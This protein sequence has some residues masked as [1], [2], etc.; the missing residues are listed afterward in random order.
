MDDELPI[1]IRAVLEV[2]GKP[3][4]HVEKSI[5]D[6][7]K[8]L[9]EDPGLMI[10]NDKISPILEKDKL[11]SSVAEVELVVKG[12]QNLIGFCIF[13][14]PAS[15]DV[16]KPESFSFEQRVFT[17]F[18]ND[19]LAKLH[20]VD[21]VAKRANAENA[22][23]KANMNKLIRNYLLVLIRFGVNTLEKIYNACGITHDELKQYLDDLM[24]EERI[25]EESGSYSIK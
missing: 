5:S 18:A 8:Q 17:G 14:M 23:L 2:V 25:K 7:I 15:I 24:K 3:K 13:Y 6:Y 16:L 22:Y 1:R 21:M 11:W 19:L 12:L 4:E 9:K 10:M 20:R